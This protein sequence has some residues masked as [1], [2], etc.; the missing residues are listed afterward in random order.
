ME[1]PLPGSHRLAPGS[2]VT[3]TTIAGRAVEGM[4]GTKLV[5]NFMGHIVYTKKASPTG[6]F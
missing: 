5:A 2:T 4:L 6:V 3:R 1:L